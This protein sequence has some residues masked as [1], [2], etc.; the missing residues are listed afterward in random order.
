MVRA[1]WI[2]WLSPLWVGDSC[3][4]G[5]AVWIVLFTSSGVGDSGGG[6]RVVIVLISVTGGGGSGDE[7]AW[8]TGVEDGRAWVTGV[9]FGWTVS[10]GL[11]IMK[12]GGRTTS[13]VTGVGW[14]TTEVDLVARIS[15]SC[16]KQ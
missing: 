9:G 15:G 6:R 2:V 10:T 13:V 3:G 14:F 4:G 1:V 5:R 12:D 16:S 11:G 7:R 8:V